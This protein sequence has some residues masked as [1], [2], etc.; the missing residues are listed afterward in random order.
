M[1]IGFATSFSLCLE[2]YASEVDL[3]MEEC[4]NVATCSPLLSALNKAHPQ[5]CTSPWTGGGPQRI[6]E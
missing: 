3:E 5:V 4:L 1:G 6:G 2:S